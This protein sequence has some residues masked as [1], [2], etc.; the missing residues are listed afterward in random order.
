MVRSE[1]PM[2]QHTITAMPSPLP[3]LAIRVPQ[4]APHNLRVRYT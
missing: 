2:Q 4:K 1:T 3:S